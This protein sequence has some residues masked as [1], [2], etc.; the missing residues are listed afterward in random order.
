MTTT[1]AM[2][3]DDGNGDDGNGDD[4]NGNGAM[5]SGVMGYDDN[6]DGDGRRQRQQ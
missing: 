4:G 3:T 5:G 6:D 1:M 2:T